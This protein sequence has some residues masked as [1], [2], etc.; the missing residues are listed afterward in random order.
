M[1]VKSN[2]ARRTLRG[3]TLI[4]LLVVVLILS[5]LMAVALPLYLNAVADAG[6]KTCRSNMQSI[7][8]AEAAFKV[9]DPNHQYTADLTKLTDFTGVP[10]C[11]NSGTYSVVLNADGSIT[12]HCSIAAHDDN[13]TGGTGFTPGKDNQ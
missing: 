3:F 5:I 7:A 8:D 9:R 10:I 11:P 6:R 12:I 2:R 4:E 13:G 1:F